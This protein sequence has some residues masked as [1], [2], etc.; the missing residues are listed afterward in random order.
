[1]KRFYCLLIHILVL[2]SCIKHVNNEITVVGH[3]KGTDIKE[4]SLQSDD[5]TYKTPVDS[6]GN[7]ILKFVY[8]QPRVYQLNFDDKLD[9]FLIPGDSVTI[10][11][12]NG[13]YKFLGGQSAT[14]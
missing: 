3:L 1:M 12:N 8:D 7:F 14:L 13:D 2:A 10:N 11:K 6:N 9:L 5:L 4:I